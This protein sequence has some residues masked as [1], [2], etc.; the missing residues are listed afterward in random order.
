MKK[1][2]F[3]LFLLSGFSLGANNAFID[4]GIAK[5]LM[6][7]NQFKMYENNLNLLKESKEKKLTIFYLT[8]TKVAKGSKS[9]DRAIQKLNDSGKEVQG[10]IV[11]R[12]FPDT[13]TLMDFLV[14]SYDYGIKGTLKIHPLI[15][16][17]FKV[18]RV[19]A[20]ALSYCPVDDNF[21]FRECEN[22][23]LAVGDITLTD[24]FRMVSLKDKKYEDYYFKLIEA[25]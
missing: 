23:F 18:T 1:I 19:P 12:G 11:L 13:K 10:F 8:S 9:F 14:N 6:G 21:T 5:F 15:F 17:T 4:P 16:N 20:F 2:L 3:S 7:P 25:K 24:F 22:K